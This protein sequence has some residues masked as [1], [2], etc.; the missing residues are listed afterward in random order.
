MNLF[1]L[2]FFFVAEN[3]LGPLNKGVYVMMSGLDLE[4]LV[5]ASGPVGSVHST[6]KII[7]LTKSVCGCHVTT[8][9]KQRLH[10]NSEKSLELIQK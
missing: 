8:Q 5:L 1:C 10:W 6:N 2:F 7:L 3:I 4:R 9:E